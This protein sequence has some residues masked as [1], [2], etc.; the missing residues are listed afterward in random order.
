MSN[1]KEEEKDRSVRVSLPTWM[2]EPR[3]NLHHDLTNNETRNILKY[4][5]RL[6]PHC[7]EKTGLHPYS[8]T[9]HCTAL[10]GSHLEVAGS[11]ALAQRSGTGGL[12][13]PKQWPQGMK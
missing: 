11:F 12:H 6:E 4:S 8:S 7:E 1:E 9:L 10:Y 3:L 13:E 2:E 5:T